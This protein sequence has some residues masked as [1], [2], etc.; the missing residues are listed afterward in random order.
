MVTSSVDV[1]PQADFHDSIKGS[2]YIFLDKIFIQYEVRETTGGSTFLRW[3]VQIHYMY[4]V[5]RLYSAQ[6]KKLQNDIENDEK[7]IVKLKEDE[8]REL[9]VC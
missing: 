1:M 8:K 7:N 5:F 6:V 9:E 4:H 3:N 2:L